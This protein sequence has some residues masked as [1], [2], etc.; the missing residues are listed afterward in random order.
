MMTP[1][2]CRAHLT[3]LE[4]SQQA[5]ARLVGITPQHFRKMLRQV[6]PLEIP[7]AVELLLP[8]LTP[9]KVRRLVAE[10]EAAEAP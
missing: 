4:I 3:R 9:A 7:R 5:F 2:Q 6:E 1:D 10:L 8:L